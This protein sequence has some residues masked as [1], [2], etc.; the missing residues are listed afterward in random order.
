VRILSRYIL[1]EFISFL[2]YALLAFI[3]VFI[4][5]DLV[6]K[7]DKFIDARVGVKLIALNYLFYLPW[8]ITLVMPVA[9]LLA[10]MFSLG[11]L[12]GDNEITAVK[13][14]G[15]SLYRILFPI[16]GLSL[17]VGLLVMAFAEVVVPGANLQ[18]KQIEEY[19]DARR[20]GDFGVR[21]SVTLFSNRERDRDNVFLANGDGRIIY[22]RYY[23]ARSRTAEGVFIISPAAPE[24]AGGKDDGFARILS[25]I[26]A[27][28]MAWKND[29]WVL[30]NAVQRSFLENGVN[31][32]HYPTL[33]ASFVNRK[34]FDFAQVS[35]QPES[36]NF[37]QLRE[38]IRS[39]KVKGGD[40]SEWLVDLYLKV[41]FPFVSF[42]IVFFGAPMVAGSVK[43][44]KAASFGLALMISF[45]FYAFINIFQVLGR[46]ETVDPLLAAWISNIVFFSLGL[47]MHARASK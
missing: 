22:A 14:S 29:Q 10:T 45:A 12:V 9:M 35:L 23:V 46:S 36:M 15:I 37:L 40:A 38:Y 11:R 18:Q 21:Y 47:V 20:H 30:Y 8:V 25:R 5:V 19:I 2:G 16:Y 33:I 31:I 34:P 42:V 6:D 7:M 26:D 27:D 1:K 17:L 28:S 44:G 32:E 24:P 4:L 39:I 43:R 3:A 41:A 13:A